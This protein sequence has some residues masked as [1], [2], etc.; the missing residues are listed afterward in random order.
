MVCGVCV[1]QAT[2][3][4]VIGRGQKGETDKGWEER[5]RGSS[6]KREKGEI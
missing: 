2:D 6:E 5:K 4:G 3:K 1:S